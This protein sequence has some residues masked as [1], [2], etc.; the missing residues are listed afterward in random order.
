MA[1]RKQVERWV[2]GE[3]PETIMLSPERVQARAAEIIECMVS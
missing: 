1:R 3:N 2:S